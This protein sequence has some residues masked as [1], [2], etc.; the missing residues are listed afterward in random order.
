MHDFQLRLKHL[1]SKVIRCVKEKK[2]QLRQELLLIKELISILFA[3]NSSGCF[4]EDEKK[5]L[6]RLE[7][8]KK[9]HYE[10]TA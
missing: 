1:K 10:N 9:K 8:K 2:A 5:S 3:A 6:F 7:T 4:S